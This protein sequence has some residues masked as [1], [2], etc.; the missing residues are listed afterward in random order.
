[1]APFVAIN[2]SENDQVVEHGLF[3]AAQEERCRGRGF[4]CKDQ[5]PGL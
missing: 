2:C 5:K 1:M 4:F 3:E